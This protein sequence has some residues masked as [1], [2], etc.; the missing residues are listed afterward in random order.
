MDRTCR[1]LYPPWF[2]NNGEPY[3]SRPPRTDRKDRG[4]DSRRLSG[5]LPGRFSMISELR[6][7]EDLETNAGGDPQVG[8]C[9][10]IGG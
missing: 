5:V 3:F 7:L 8:L 4:R 9:A 1:A 10:W 2:A 6:D